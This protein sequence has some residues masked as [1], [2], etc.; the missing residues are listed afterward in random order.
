MAGR[1]LEHR[2]LSLSDLRQGSSQP[3]H[4]AEFPRKIS[5]WILSDLSVPEEHGRAGPRHVGLPGR[6]NP[7][8][9]GRLSRSVFQI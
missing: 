9:A 1:G 7:A 5:L 6:N 4:F 8:A 3:E 2:D